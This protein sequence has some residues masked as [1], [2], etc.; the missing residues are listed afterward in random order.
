MNPIDERPVF[1]TIAH[2]DS[3]LSMGIESALNG[4]PS[5][6]TL[7]WRHGDGAQPNLAD[8]GVLIA[9][10]QLGLQVARSHRLGGHSSASMRGRVL[11][12]S[13]REREHE[14]RQALEQGVHGYLPV[15]CS[16]VEL[17]EAVH[18]LSRG[19]RYLSP[20]VAARM[21][22]SFGRETMT[23]REQEV[24][25][26]LACGECNKSIA[27]ELDIAIGTV[28]AHVKSIMHKLGASSRTKAICIANERGLIEFQ[29]LEVAA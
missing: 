15:H 6:R 26:L 3:L 2:P 13:N 1:V 24:L 29:G 14:V 17:V 8:G 25:T 19:L 12:M 18:A 10:Y 22:N 16:P 23:L 11:V 7:V 20:P 21:A 9:D 27:R 4:E 28:K 5:F